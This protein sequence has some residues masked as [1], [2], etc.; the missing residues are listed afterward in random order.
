[1]P[2]W[3]QQA[4]RQEQMRMQQQQMQLQ[5]GRGGGGNMV[6]DGLKA[7]KQYKQVKDLMGSGSSA[8]V[9]PN[10]A[11]SGGQSLMGA[12]GQSGSTAGT[13]ANGQSLIGGGESVGSLGATGGQTAGTSVAGTALGAA[14]AAYGAYNAY[15][16]IKN[17]NPVQAGMGGV[18]AGLGLNAMG[19]ALGPYGWAAM[20][21][22]PVVMSMMNKKSTKEI[23][24]DRWKDAGQKDPGARDY[25]AGTAGQ[26]SRDES[27]L[28][29]DAIRSNPDN[30]NAAKDWD[31]FSKPQQ[32][33]FLNT[34]LQEKAVSERKGGIYYN[35]DR[36]K[37]L[38]DQ[39]RTEGPGSQ[40]LRTI[41]NL[42]A[43]VS[44]G[45]GSVMIPRRS[46][47]KSPGISLSG[48]RISY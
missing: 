30:Y 19:L 24:S 13:L 9:T 1:M 43:Q 26:Q 21:A 15:Q 47:T 5:Q 18:G 42:P 36:A 25:F 34:L 8:A 32:D 3:L 41:S 11:M 39:I 48:Q 44:S 16:G 17:R 45:Q 22:A 14:G 35:D 27:L 31:T 38:A 7:Y 29:A 33:R 23:Q 10:A 40:N 28:T 20:A 37:A 46:R 6:S 2:L 12:A 4:V